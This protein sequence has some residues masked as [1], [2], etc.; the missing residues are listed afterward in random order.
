MSQFKFQNVKRF[1]RGA[2]MSNG[3]GLMC[4]R[5]NTNPD[6]RRS[7]QAVVTAELFN[8]RVPARKR[9]VVPVAYCKADTPEEIQS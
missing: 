8:T 4:T 3:E 2:K 7:R 6:Q 1:K 5:C 9:I